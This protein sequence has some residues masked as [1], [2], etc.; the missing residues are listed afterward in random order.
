MGAGRQRG[1]RR[2]VMAGS[3]SDVSMMSAVGPKY[4]KVMWQHGRVT[5]GR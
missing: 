5:C 3:G 4:G 1:G 2:G